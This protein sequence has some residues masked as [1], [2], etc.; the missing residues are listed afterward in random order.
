MQSPDYVAIITNAA[1]RARILQNRTEDGGRIKIGGRIADDDGPA[2]RLGARLDHRHSL[3]M[4]V[5]VDE[6]SARPGRREAPRHCHRF[7]RCGRFIEERCIG[8]CE[9]GEVGDHGLEVQQRLEAP[10]TDLRLIRRI[11]RVPG[12][13]FQ[14]VALNDGRQVRAVIALA[15]QG[16]H[17][18]VARNDPAHFGQELG[19]GQRRSKAE[20]PSLAN[21]GRHRLVDERIQARRVHDLQH[22]PHVVRLRPDVPLRE[23][24]RIERPYSHIH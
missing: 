6:K 16:D 17:R 20:R 23:T 10:L 2:K 12:G 9:P 21:V 11:G 4:A 24:E 5:V 7:S 15:D 18:L 14:H 3:R 22:P 13:I 1:G 8:D 19:F